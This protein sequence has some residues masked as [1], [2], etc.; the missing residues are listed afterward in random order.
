MNNDEKWLAIDRFPNYCVSDT[1]RIKNRKTNH[2]LK[3]HNDGHGY[4]QVILSNN[5]YKQSQRVHRLVAN[6][7]VDGRDECLEV[8]HIDGCKENNRACNLEWVTPSENSLHAYTTGLS[9]RSP[10]AG[11]PPSRVRVVES[12]EMFDSI[13]ECARCLGV[14]REGIVACVNGRSKSYRGLHF[15]RV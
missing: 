14:S 2:I 15:E 1:G 9:H 4:P 6:A 10:L 7:F 5:G 13:S 8:N 11:T 12:G 3:S